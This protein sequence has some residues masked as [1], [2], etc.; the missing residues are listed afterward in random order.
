M[1]STK[2]VVD[3]NA[4][5]VDL[6]NLAGHELV[7]TAMVI[8]ELEN[9]KR[10]NA[11]SD[12]A[13]RA[14]KAVRFIE[15]NRDKFIFDLNDYDGNIGEGFDTGYVDNQIID[16]C[17]IHGYGL[18][19]R[20]LLL[21][22]KAEAFEIPLLDLG[23]EDIEDDSYTG[24]RELFLDMSSNTDQQTLSNF[25]TD[26]GNNYLGL[27]KN[28]YL[29]IWDK[30]SP[31]FDENGEVNGYKMLDKCC[32]KWDGE[33]LE[34]LKWKKISS[35][36]MGEIKPVNHKQEILFDMLQD[37]DITVKA[38]FGKFG[39]GK[40]FCMLSHAISMIETG[41]FEK[42]VFV[43]N[44]IELEDAGQIGFL[45]GDDFSKLLPYCMPLADHIGGVEGLKMF[46]DK[47]LIELQHLGTIRGRDIKN[48][49]IYVTEV[50]NNTKNHVK[51]LLGRVG[52]GSQ[53]WLNGDLKQVDKESFVHKNGIKAVSMLGGNALYGQVVLDKTE[54]S[55]TAELSEL[56]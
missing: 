28:E 15:E 39:T 11:H 23:S 38:C 3:T 22:F 50:Q 34:K 18:A 12:L 36:F 33:Y 41:K 44:A 17:R 54:R 42:L 21:K 31:T 25:F 8:R 26:S 32:F 27:K 7:I 10:K 13:Y 30:N 48:S 24:V 2:Y 46:V 43:R 5:L 19:T 16:C 4:M 49:I 56:I 53:L 29:I 20:D 37:K 9:H 40:D 14:R 45:P 52:E 51:L 47:G 6:E 55:K 1:S 35:K